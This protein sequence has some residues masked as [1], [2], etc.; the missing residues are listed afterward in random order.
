MGDWTTGRG[1]GRAERDGPSLADIAR[2]EAAAAAQP[3]KVQG[4]P[5]HEPRDPGYRHDQRLSRIRQRVEEI[6][7]DIQQLEQ[8]EPVNRRH[9]RDIANMIRR[10]Q[11]ELDRLPNR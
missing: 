8:V 3:K 10:L 1:Y 5:C 6:Q 4:R 11:R 2:A 7:S 9:R